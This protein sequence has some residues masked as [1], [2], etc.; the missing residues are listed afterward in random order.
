MF[1][2]ASQAGRARAGEI[3]PAAKTET[4]AGAATAVIV[5][6]V[7]EKC[8]PGDAALTN[9][10]QQILGSRRSESHGTD[11]EAIAFAQRAAGEPHPWP[12][13][14]VASARTLAP[15]G[16]LQKFDAWLTELG[17]SR[18]RRC[19]VAGGRAPD[20]DE[21]IVVVAVDALADLAP[22]PM[23]AR[24]G[25]WLSVAAR[26][27]VHAQGGRVIALGPSGTPR[28]LPTSFDG[29]TLRAWF[30]PDGP[31]EFTVQ[32]IAEVASG[33]R[34]VLETH[35]SADVEPPVV[36]TP[37]PAPGEGEARDGQ[38]EETA[39]AT[40]LTRARVWAGLAPFERDARLDAVAREHAVRIARAR[41]LAHDAGDGDPAERLRA[42]G[43]ETHDVGENLA[44]AKSALMAHRATWA[45]PSHRENIL[46]PE[47]ER[48]G[49]AIAH[50][51]HGDLWLVEIFTS[52]L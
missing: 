22:L 33:P 44:T 2:L 17:Q 16:T 3:A 8:A 26:L 23:R 42:A 1:V 7:A 10:A 38:D 19:G 41:R 49:L 28:P 34:P 35:V 50:D 52:T 6:A 51:S 18:L 39:L 14:W 37:N 40:M 20:G 4:A 48:V 25:Q 11:A 43:L 15:N 31:G 29:R 47:F 9:M 12:K 13:V 32:V 36:A 21:V 30:A 46:R 5:D 24:T 27:R 45:S